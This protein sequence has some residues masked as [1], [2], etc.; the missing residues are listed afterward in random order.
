MTLLMVQRIQA[1]S[2]RLLWARQ[3]SLRLSR[4]RPR[5]ERLQLLNW[6]H[7]VGSHHGLTR[8]QRSFC[9]SM[10]AYILATV[11]MCVW[12][13]AY[14]VQPSI[15]APLILGY[16]LFLMLVMLI[17]PYNLRMAQKAM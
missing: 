11:S 5:D 14:A 7:F 10:F 13:L 9:R 16:N 4:G 15:A 1:R 2:D 3:E 12:V 8:A 6:A 17:K